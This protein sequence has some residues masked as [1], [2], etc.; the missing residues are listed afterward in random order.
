MC[1][2]R[3]RKW[4]VARALTAQSFSPLGDPKGLGIPTPTRPGAAR[5]PSDALHKLIEHHA[6]GDSA[7]LIKRAGEL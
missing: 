4:S 3:P 1:C 6:D 2:T 5:S 7:E